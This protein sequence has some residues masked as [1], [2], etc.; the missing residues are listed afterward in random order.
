MKEKLEAFIKETYP[1]AV[2]DN[3]IKSRWGEEIIFYPHPKAEHP[4]TCVAKGNK[5]EILTEF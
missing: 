3:Y 2:L 4:Y 5:C 1:D